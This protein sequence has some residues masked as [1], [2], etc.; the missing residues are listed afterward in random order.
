MGGDEIR[1]SEM[2]FGMVACTDETF[3]T[4]AV[5]TLQETIGFGMGTENFATSGA[6]FVATSFTSSG[7]Q[8]KENSETRFRIGDV[9]D[10]GALERGASYV[11]SA[12]GFQKNERSETAFVS[13]D[14][15]DEITFLGGLI[16]SFTTCCTEVSCE[17]NDVV[18]IFLA[19]EGFREM[20]C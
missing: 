4:G 6:L 15:G 5:G 11:F 20:T 1:T 8:K 17:G 2:M 12:S 10:V 9:D 7:T 18:V 16:Q 19:G 14:T 13:G 3:W